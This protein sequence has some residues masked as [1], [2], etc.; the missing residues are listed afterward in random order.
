MREDLLL[1]QIFCKRYSIYEIDQ[2]QEIF[3]ND[4][5]NG[6]DKINTSELPTDYSYTKFI[7]ET[8][9]IEVANESK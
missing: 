5:K 6:F 7:K 1:H 8:A 3:A 2:V 9:I 4:I